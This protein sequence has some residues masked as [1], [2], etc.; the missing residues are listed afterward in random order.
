MSLSIRA[1]LVV[2]CIVIATLMTIT[3]ARSIDN[4]IV[5][6]PLNWINKVG[7]VIDGIIP[8]PDTVLESI[9]GALPQDLGVVLDGPILADIE[10]PTGDCPLANS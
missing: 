3:E 1:V 6:S 10:L 4:D 9:G 7:Q 5:K 2:V 8:N